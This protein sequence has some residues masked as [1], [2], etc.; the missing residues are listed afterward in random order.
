LKQFQLL[1]KGKQNVVYQHPG[2]LY[3]FHQLLKHSVGILNEILDNDQQPKLYVIHQPLSKF[4]HFESCI[5]S[6][7]YWE[8]L[9]ELC[10]FFVQ[11]YFISQK[12]MLA[13]LSLFPEE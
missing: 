7:S 5:I 10:N 13:T 8:T 2:A 6:I 9:I 1:G 12:P 4:V 3:S 11:L